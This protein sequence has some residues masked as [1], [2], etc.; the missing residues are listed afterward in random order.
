MINRALHLA[1]KDAYKGEVRKDLKKDIAFSLHVLAGLSS[2]YVCWKERS[3]FF[4]SFYLT[5]HKIYTGYYLELL[6][7][8]K[9]VS[10]F[11]KL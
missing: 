11:F 5:S 8:N 2:S 9:N 4:L 7:F 6:F 1:V 10:I 3:V